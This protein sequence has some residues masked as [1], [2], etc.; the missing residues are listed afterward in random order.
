ML[1]A[2]VSD[3][4][5]A[6]PGSLDPCSQAWTV[7]GLMFSNIANTACEQFSVGAYPSESVAEHTTDNTR[8]KAQSLF[9]GRLS[10]VF[11][12]RRFIYL[13]SELLTNATCLLSGD[14]EGTFIVP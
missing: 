4:S 3:L 9:I 11:G 13:I 14:H 5:A 12:N 8:T 2:I 6:S 1:F 10:S 7:L